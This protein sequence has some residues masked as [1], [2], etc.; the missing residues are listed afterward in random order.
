MTRDDVVGG[1]RV[2][3]PVGQEHPVGL[4]V[5]DLL[6]GRRR[7]QHVAADAAAGEVA[8]RVGLDAEVDRGDGEPLR[9]FG[10]HDVGVVGADLAG[11]VG[12]QHRLLAAHP[13]QQLVG[14]GQRVA[15]EHA[16]LHRA[17]AAQVPHHRAGVDAGDA[18]DALADQFV[19]QR[20]GGPPV[21]RPR[22]RVAHRVAG[23]P[24]LVAAALGVL[25]VPAG[26]ADLRRGGDHDLAVIAGVGQ[27]LLVAGHAGGEH[28][29][30]ERLADR[31]ERRAGEDPAV[32]EDQH[33][34]YCSRRARSS[35]LQPLRRTRARSSP[36]KPVS[37]SVP[38]GSRHRI[39][40]MP[41]VREGLAGDAA[42]GADRGDRL[43]AGSRSGRRR[44]AAP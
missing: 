24:D 29:L 15:G 43:V 28:R 25:A 40:R 32:L 37:I 5:G 10:F 8:R 7:R 19:L 13:V 12:A 1:G 38:D 3:G 18:D 17:A 11:Q 27:R 31:A 14:V 22:R 34:P 33:A 44:C 35:C 30:A 42:L 26:V 23:D 20:S 21:R 2:A 4:E 39:A 9:P 36:R 41:V 6:E 16:G